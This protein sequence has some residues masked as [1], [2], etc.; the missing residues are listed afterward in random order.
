MDHLVACSLEIG[1]NNPN[2]VES[3]K[4]TYDYVRDVFYHLSCLSSYSTHDR[5]ILEQ[6]QIP[7]PKQIQMTQ[8]EGGGVL[9]SKSIQTKYQVHVYYQP[10]PSTPEIT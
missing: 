10:L 3:T 9:K 6:P 7:T 5:Q 4:M 2:K 1:T 8:E